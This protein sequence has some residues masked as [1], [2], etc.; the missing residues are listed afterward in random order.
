MEPQE[1]RERIDL[2]AHAISEDEPVG[3]G[4]L[5]VMLHEGADVDEI[6]AALEPH[7]M[8][9]LSSYFL[10]EALLWLR[11]VMDPDRV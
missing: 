6:I 4:P 10:R 2:L 9:S 5:V 8:T 11:D 7:G 3:A 1:I